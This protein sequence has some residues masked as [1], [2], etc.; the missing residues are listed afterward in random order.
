MIKEMGLGQAYSEKGGM[1]F[2]YA[3]LLLIYIVNIMN[4]LINILKSLHTHK[5][6]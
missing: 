2:G 5:L 4:L 1:A 6:T 3:G